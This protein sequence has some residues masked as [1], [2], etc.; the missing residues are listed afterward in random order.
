MAP[1]RAKS[2][3]A[4][5]SAKQAALAKR[6]QAMA[7]RSSAHEGLAA[8]ARVLGIYG[9]G[10]FF[11][12]VNEVEPSLLVR[13]EPS[14]NIYERRRHFLQWVWLAVCEDIDRHKAIEREATAKWEAKVAVH[15]VVVARNQ[16]KEAW[17]AY[18]AGSGPDPGPRPCAED[19]DENM[20]LLFKFCDDDYK[21]AV[22]A[23]PLG[24]V[25]DG[26]AWAVRQLAAG[27]PCHDDAGTAEPGTK[28]APWE[29]VLTAWHPLEVDGIANVAAEWG[30]RLTWKQARKYG[31][32]EDFPHGLYITTW[33]L[34]RGLGRFK[35]LT[36]HGSLPVCLHA[37]LDPP[38]TS[39][40]PGHLPAC[41][42]SRRCRPAALAVGSWP[43]GGRRYDGHPPRRRRWRRQQ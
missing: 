20:P 7:D 29:E 8:G 37:I 35:D 13:V 26:C 5:L 15:P 30:T 43:V 11:E 28:R 38:R 14:R 3:N 25:S 17:A 22:D 12:G 34:T 40:H 27:T 1:K 6:L 23:D 21:A 24:S 19:K 42:I 36:V 31:G 10:R 18:R 39:S 9:S 2:C 4:T 41:R 16:W 33:Y 32:T